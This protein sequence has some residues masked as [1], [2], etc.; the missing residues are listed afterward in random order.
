MNIVST[1][2]NAVAQAVT[3]LYG[4]A[5]EPGK[6]LVNPTPPDFTGDYSV[7]IFPFVKV[8]KKSPDATAAEIGE[9]L[10]KNI[11]EIKGHNVVKGFLNL[12]ISEA[13]WQGFLQSVV[14]DSTY[15]RQGRPMA[16]K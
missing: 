15:G 6:V 1:L 16:K 12:E 5:T 10:S 3:Q 4:E 14:Q 2:Q 11:P 13:Y 7:V 9:Y 8:A